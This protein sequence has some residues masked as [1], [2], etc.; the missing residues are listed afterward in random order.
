MNGKWKGA[1]L[2]LVRSSILEGYIWFRIKSVFC[3]I[4]KSQNSCLLQHSGW[5]DASQQYRHLFHICLRTAGLH[6]C[7]AD[8]WMLGTGWKTGKQL[9]LFLSMRERWRSPKSKTTPR[10]ASNLSLLCHFNWSMINRNIWLHLEELR[11]A[12]NLCLRFRVF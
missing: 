6:S 5:N 7:S 2:I 4:Y 1:Q 10:L 3:T 12:R 8:V 11:W 9:R